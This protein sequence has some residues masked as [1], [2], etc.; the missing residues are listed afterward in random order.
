MDQQNTFKLIRQL[1]ADLGL[2]QEMFAA[3]IGVTKMIKVNLLYWQCLGL[4]GYK[5]K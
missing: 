3:K 1:R 2:K 5:K 4:R